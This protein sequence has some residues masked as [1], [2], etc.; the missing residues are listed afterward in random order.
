MPTQ[1]YLVR[2]GTTVLTAE[3]RI[4]GSTE[5]SLSDEGRAQ[6][7]ALAEPLRMR[8]AGCHLRESDGPHHGDR[9]DHWRI[10]P[11]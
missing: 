2:H 10:P 3:D 1:F 4:A 7:T 9:T 6:V 5:V 11:A 8:H